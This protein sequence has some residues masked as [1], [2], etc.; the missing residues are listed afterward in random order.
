[1]EDTDQRY[2]LDGP[3]GNPTPVGPLVIPPEAPSC[4]AGHSF[5][6]PIELSEDGRSI[7]APLKLP[8]MDPHQR[9]THAGWAHQ[10]EKIYDALTRT[11]QTNPR[12]Y[13]YANCSAG[14]MLQRREIPNSTAVEWRVSST[15]CHDRFCEPCAQRRAWD[16][17]RALHARISS[18]KTV[19]LITLTQISHPGEPL[20]R[21]IV[22]IWKAFRTLRDWS[23]WQ[24][25]VR[26]GAA[27]ME[28]T[29]GKDGDRWHAHLH[30]VADADFM[31]F[32]ALQA[33]WKGITN[34]SFR[35]RIERPKAE[36][37]SVYAAKYAAKG[38]EPALAETPDHL[39]EI[40]LAMKGQRAVRC[41]GDW[42]GTSFAADIEED[43]LEDDTTSGGG[44]TTML[45][46]AAALTAALG[47]DAFALNAVASTPAGR[48]ALALANAPPVP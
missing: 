45:S 46:F 16:I 25:C 44:W 20:A 43:K 24:K 17:Q 39:D 10:R 8:P 19:S 30:I 12:R 23:V 3:T 22:E 6:V 33:V 2:F 13:A 1:M 4:P 18:L 28:V 42:Y 47:G 5:L 36:S 35:V 31:D 27:F 21:K 26:G 41:F 38:I 32:Y 48:A 37:G 9:F 14:A 11:G 15:R 34:G 40:I 7:E 29:R